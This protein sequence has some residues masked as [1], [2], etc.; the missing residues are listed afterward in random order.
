MDPMAVRSVSSRLVV[1][2]LAALLPATAWAA[3]EPAS[4]HRIAMALRASAVLSDTE[5]SAQR[6]T[7]L[8]LPAPGAPRLLDGPPVRLW[9]EIRAQP[10]AGPGAVTIIIGPPGLR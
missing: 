1:G 3:P 6:G 10:S 9:D 2:L 8:I 5:A 4:D 7:G